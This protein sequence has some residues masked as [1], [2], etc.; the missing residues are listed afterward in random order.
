[1]A[2]AIAALV[3][4]A[5]NDQS[6]VDRQHAAFAEL[7]SRFEEAAFGWA[8]RRVHDPEEARDVCQDAF[9]TAWLKLRH[10]RDGAAFGGWL[11]RLVATQ[12][13]RRMRRAQLEMDSSFEAHDNVFEKR[14]LIADALSRL[15]EAEHR[16]VVM[17]Y[18]LGR[19]IDEIARILEIP[20]G[21]A[22]KRL[23]SARIV[24]RKNLPRHVRAEFMRV[25]PSRQFLQQVREGLFDEY[26]GVYRFDRRPDHTITIAREGEHLIGYGGGQRI[27]LASIGENAFV[28][29]A[30]DGEGRFERDRAGRIVQ[31]TYYE[32]GARLGIARKV[33]SSAR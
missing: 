5:R 11:R 21:T 24:I 8:L 22:G 26:A 9:V 12:C 32:F 3:E 1:M 29:D 2:D 10:L 4:Q 18:F 19:T 20:R 15:S 30:F 27:V 28:P 25:R 13:N 17:F 14:R 31:F 23:Y 33:S 16:V 7:V 6:P